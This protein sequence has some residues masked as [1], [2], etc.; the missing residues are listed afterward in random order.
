MLF[1]CYIQPTTPLFKTL[2]RGSSSLMFSVQIIISEVVFKRIALL[3]TEY[4]NHRTTSSHRAHFV[5]KAFIFSI[6]NNFSAAVYMV[7]FDDQYDI[8]SLQQKCSAATELDSFN[9]TLLAPSASSD[10]SATSAATDLYATVLGQKALNLFSLFLSNILLG[11][12][13]ETF[14]PKMYTYCNKNKPCHAVQKHIC[15]CGK[16]HEADVSET[17]N[18]GTQGHERR[19]LPSL[20]S[21]SS[22]NG[23]IRKMFS[24]LLD[25]SNL[26]EFDFIE[27]YDNLSDIIVSYTFATAFAAA[28]PL[29]G[30]LASLSLALEVR[31]DI[32]QQCR[33]YRRPYPQEA[34]TLRAAE[35]LLSYT[36]GF[37]WL[38]NACILIFLEFN[39]KKGESVDLSVIVWCLIIGLVCYFVGQSCVSFRGNS[40]AVVAMLEKRYEWR[41]NKILMGAEDKEDAIDR[42]YKLAASDSLVSSKSLPVYLRNKSTHQFYKNIKKQ[43]QFGDQ[44]EASEKEE[45][46]STRGVKEL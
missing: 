25:Q 44:K 27:Q 36:E 1:H 19:A 17:T 26:M 22:S 42:K 23:A 28:F 5:K 15:C 2:V 14:V 24:P 37:V 10:S 8:F 33:H 20:T 46:G 12:L 38:N 13:I 31:L 3:L 7:Y 29:G 41:A 32:Y 21:S 30:V 40:N 34:S 45:S 35:V 39:D 43:M 18:Q 9:T 11:L 4:E 6:I 16:H